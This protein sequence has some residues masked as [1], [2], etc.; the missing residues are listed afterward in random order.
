MKKG[1]I[2]FIFVL[3]SVLFSAC[4]PSDDSESELLTRTQW[5]FSMSTQ[6]TVR[7][8]VEKEEDFE[9]HFNEI[10]NIYD[11]YHVLTDNF[12]SADSEEVLSIYDINEIVNSNEAEDETSIEIDQKLFELLELGLEVEELTDGYFNMTMGYIIDIWKDIF[13]TDDDGLKV[14]RVVGSK[15][16]DDVINQA[17]IDAKAIEI[18]ENPITLE[19]IEGKY[20]LTM[21]KGAKLDLGAIAKGYA[22]QKAVE[23]L[24]DVNMKHY[25]IDAGSSSI[26]V[27]VKPS[28]TNKE[29]I[30]NLL[31]PE[32]HLFGDVYGQTRMTDTTIT[33]S[34]YYK[35]YVED[36]DGRIYTHIVSPKTKE[37]SSYYYSLTLISPD[38]GLLDGL[39]TALYCM[40]IDV[41]ELFL[42]QNE[43]IELI[44]KDQNGVVIRFNETSRVVTR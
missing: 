5:F 12:Q 29:F 4:T 32:R 9:T 37:P 10:K 40:P 11:T 3:F 27:G 34:A 20:M 42:D 2:L 22:T 23:Y 41:L 1:F 19:V 18:I 28:E 26:S 16:P 39:S 43:G 14:P 24:K 6:V 17:K 33:T 36:N 31:D 8:H 7:L 15:V 25:M 38:A 44:G 13:Y 35:Q 21:K 30:I